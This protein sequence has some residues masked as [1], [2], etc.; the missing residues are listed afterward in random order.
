MCAVHFQNM[1]LAAVLIPPSLPAKQVLRLR[2]F[3]LA[4]L[5]KAKANLMSG[6][7]T[8]A[9]ALIRWHDPRT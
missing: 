1:N 7:L 3:G 4:A 8:S 2:R 9:E 5:K 6:K